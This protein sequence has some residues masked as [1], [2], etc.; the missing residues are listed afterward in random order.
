MKEYLAFHAQISTLS[1]DISSILK[2][3]YTVENI[4]D[5]FIIP[6]PKQRIRIKYGQKKMHIYNL[7]I[8]KQIL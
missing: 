8:I 3:K 4:S 1:L 7:I 5:I 6:P 2:M